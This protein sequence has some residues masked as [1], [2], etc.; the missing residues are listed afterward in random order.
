VQQVIRY[1]VVGVMSVL[2]AT[3]AASAWHQHGSQWAGNIVASTDGNYIRCIA[4]GE[5]AAKIA[6]CDNAS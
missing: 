6:L 4:L 5:T 2:P 1:M 3:H